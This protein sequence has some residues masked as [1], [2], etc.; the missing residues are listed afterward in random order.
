MG[1]LPMEDRSNGYEA[2][3]TAFTRA[4][5]R[6]IGPRVV[7]E[8][9]SG[10]APGTCVLDLGCGFGV[11]ITEALLQAGFEVHGV[12]A[13]A[14]M[15]AKF[16]ERF[17]E[18]RVECCPVEESAFFGRTYDAVVAWGLLFLLP[19][20]A[21][22]R[23][24]GKVAGVLNRGGQFLFTSPKEPISWLDGMTDLPSVSLGRA[25]YVAEMAAQGVE[26]VGTDEDEGGNYYYFGRKG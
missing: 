18:V 4:R 24:I 10:L 23:L 13:S 25:V 8:W 16:R 9:A 19:A 2:I 6:T 5:D 26:L 14:T 1:G 20:E 12:D 22:V 17:P 11:P 21:Q 7:K 3:A 15:V